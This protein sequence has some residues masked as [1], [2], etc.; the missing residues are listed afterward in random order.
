M[1]STIV[2]ADL[3]LR[4]TD[5]IGE[6]ATARHKNDAARAA[7]DRAEPEDFRAKFQTWIEACQKLRTAYFEKHYPAL[8]TLTR[9]DLEIEEGAQPL[10]H[11]RVVIGNQDAGHRE[12]SVRWWCCG[13]DAHHGVRGR[14]TGSGEMRCGPLP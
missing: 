8:F 10:S 11:Y 4:V 5:K 1:R 12:V 13:T 3:R 9:Y 6:G 2:E 7:C 14:R